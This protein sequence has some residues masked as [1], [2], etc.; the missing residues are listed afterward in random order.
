MVEWGLS[1]LGPSPAGYLLATRRALGKSQDGS[2][3]GFWPRVR[4]DAQ[5]GPA[6]C[7]EPQGSKD[8]RS[9]SYALFLTVSRLKA[10]N[11]CGESPFSPFW[12][13]LW[14]EPDRPRQTDH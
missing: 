13:E 8:G 4:Y 6:R 1:P 11:L 3:W 10:I 5:T 7:Q 12:G 2:G 9:F 14:D